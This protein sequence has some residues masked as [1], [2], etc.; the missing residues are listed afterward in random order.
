[1]TDNTVNSENYI[2]VSWDRDI[3]R[4][5]DDSFCVGLFKNKTQDAEKNTI[6][7]KGS[8]LPSISN[9]TFMFYGSWI[10]DKKYGKQFSVSRFEEKIGDSKKEIISYL[11][12]GLFKGLG[13]KT[14]EKIFDVY[15]KDSVKVIS[16][17][18]EALIKVK[19]ISKAQAEKICASYEE[20]HIPKELVDLLLGK[21]FSSSNIAKIHKVLKQEAYSSIIQNPYVLCNINGISFRM[22]DN[23]RVSLNIEECNHD[24]LLAAETEVIKNNFFSGK[25]GISLE[26]LIRKTSEITGI[27]N[28]KA[29]QSDIMDNLKSGDLCYKKMIC[30]GITKLYVYTYQIKNAEERLSKLIVRKALCNKNNSKDALEY[31]ST[32]TLDVNLDESQKGAVLNAFS[33]GISII[34]GGPGTGKTTTI[35]AIAEVDK[36]L[37]KNVTQYFLAPTGRA[38]RRITESSG[39]EAL[40]IHSALNLR[41]LDDDKVQSYQDNTEEDEKI[42]GATII[43]DEFSMVDMM[44]ALAL[45]ERTE[46]CRY[47]IVGDPNQLPSV[48]AGNVLKDLLESEIIPVSRLKYVH[49]QEEG[50]TINENANGMQ[51]GF[52][53]FLKN[54]DF[55][56]EYYEDLASIEDHIVKTYLKETKENPAKSIAV[57]CPYRNREAGMFSVNKKIQSIVNPYGDEFSGHNEQIFKVGDPVMHVK[58]NTEDAVNGDVGTVKSIGVNKDGEKC[59]HV[60]YE[61]GKKTFI[62]EYTAKEIDQL[63]LAYAMTIHK[64]QGSEYDTIITLLTKQHHSFVTRNIPYTAITR[65]KKKVYFFTDSDE[66]IKNAIQN[67]NLEERNTL[68]PYLIKDECAKRNLF[69]LNKNNKKAEKKTDR[70]NDI[71]GQMS[72]TFPNGTLQTV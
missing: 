46:N 67:N 26:T 40:T 45:F 36:A 33:S 49:R 59:L 20:N 14:A 56:V 11:S 44:L 23:L 48:G 62:K 70:S 41:P 24:R 66:T 54:D 19:G 63:N 32:H 72:L 61:A 2:L 68:L 7:C 1:M 16:E 64:S 34:T 3:F 55:V 9:V 51:E 35:K 53:T 38:A 12:S 17:G 50:S 15:G 31:L 10:D 69:K 30:D 29:I 21:G 27:N 22:A 58:R 28:L 71:Q 37:N 43:I 4:S 60:E 5:D 25:V 8:S 6:I 13:K 42:E 52:S 39:Y 57:L 47:I 65:A 18:P